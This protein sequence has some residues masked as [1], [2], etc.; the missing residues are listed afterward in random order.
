M[1]S[2]K[3]TVAQ[4]VAERLPHSVHL[5]GD[6]FRKMIVSGRA[7]LEPDTMAAGQKQLAL[8]HEITAMVA[9]K[10]VQAGFS[11]VLQDILL[12]DHLARLAGALSALDCGV[13][14]LAPTIAEI[15]ARERNRTKKG[16][17]A[18]TPEEL[19]RA[20]E[21]TPHIGLWLDTTDL[22]VAETVD[23][24]FARVNEAKIGV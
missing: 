23:A 13:V 21:T 18:W 8:R 20:L 16:Y 9:A 17:R 2:G 3:S 24:I 5:R 14:V 22:S 12:G 10:Y 1:A 4:A 7:E 15:E 19:S 6:T 11:V